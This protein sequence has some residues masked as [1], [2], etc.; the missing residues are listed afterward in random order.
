MTNK[1]KIIKMLTA[2]YPDINLKQSLAVGDTEGDIAM[3]S[4]VGRPIA[5]N[6]NMQ[7]A[8]AAKKR[9]WEIIVERKDVI[10]DVKDFVF[11][12]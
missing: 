4:L 12:I 3:L 2:K 7:L 8:K 11:R 5:F 1:A 6:P 9:K 10:Y